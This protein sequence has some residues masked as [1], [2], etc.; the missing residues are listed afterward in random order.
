MQDVKIKLRELDKYT[1][2]KQ[3]YKTK[4]VEKTLNPV[5]DQTFLIYVDNCEGTKLI[6]TVYD[7]DKFSTDDFM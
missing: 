2:K 7:K 6:F 5:W 4:I 3:K 1:D